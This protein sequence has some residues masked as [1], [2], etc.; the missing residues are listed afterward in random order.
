MLPQKQEVVAFTFDLSSSFFGNIGTPL[1]KIGRLDS[2]YSSCL[3]ASPRLVETGKYDEKEFLN[4]IPS[5]GNRPDK[6]ELEPTEY[7]SE[8]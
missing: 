2:I 1:L 6:N 8:L 4:Q 7:A 3:T 5:E